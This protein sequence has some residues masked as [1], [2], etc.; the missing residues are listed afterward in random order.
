MQS[1]PVSLDMYQ[2]IVGFFLPVLIAMLC[3]PSLGQYAKY[4]L[5]F[6]LVFIA[7]AGEVYFT[8]GFDLA[9]LPVTILKILSLTIGS[10]LIFWRPSGINRAIESKAGCKDKVDTTNIAF[11]LILVPL[12]LLALSTPVKAAVTMYTPDQSTIAW[13]AVTTFQN[14]TAI[15]AVDAVEYEIYLSTDGL[16]GSII[17][18]ATLLQYI[19]TFATEGMFFAGV[20]AVRIPNGTLTRIPGPITWSNSTDTALVPQPFGWV[21]YFAPGPVTKLRK[22]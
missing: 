16:T 1:F 4:W 17:G 15:P 2:G 6:A 7:A 10:Y 22:P 8:L 3:R 20:R 18:T 5:S 12:I 19:V 11:I 21:N 13:D 14:G 9:A